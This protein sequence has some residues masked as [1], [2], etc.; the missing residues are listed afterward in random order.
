MEADQREILI[1][2][3]VE[4][5]EDIDIQGGLFTQLQSRKVLQKR[6]VNKLRV[7]V[8]GMLLSHDFV[9]AVVCSF[10]T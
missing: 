3:R 6:T 4:L 1:A 10:H 9:T 7:M 2:R 8:N 5:V